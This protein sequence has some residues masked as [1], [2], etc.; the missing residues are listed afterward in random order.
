[1]DWDRKWLV[2]FNAGK[3]QHILFDWSNSTGA[4][5]V[6]MNGYVYEENVCCKMQG[7]FLGGAPTYICHFFHPSICP[8]ICPAG[9][10]SV[11][12]HISGT[13]HHLIV[14]FGTLM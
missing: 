5:D 3:T 2:Y 1:M 4:I 7:L 9:C 12:H 6:K 8:S 10:R 13:V 11:V 14:I